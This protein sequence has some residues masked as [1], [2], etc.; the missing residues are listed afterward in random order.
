MRLFADRALL[1][2]GW[3][4]NVVLDM[5]AAGLITG[6]KPDITTP[7]ADAQR[8]GGPVLPGMPNLH[9]HAFQ[10]AFAGCSERRGPDEDSFWTWRKVMYDFAARITPDQVQSIAE[11]LYVEMLKAGYT[12]VAEFHYLHHDANGEPY[13]KLTEMSDRIF[14]AA[15]TTG[16]ALTH[17]P[18][19]YGYGGFGGQPATAGQRRFIND[20]ERYATLLE[21]LFA[22]YGK[23][24]NARIGIAAHSLRAVTPESLREAVQ[25][26]NRLDDSAPIHIHIAEQKKE[27]DDCL[28]WSGQRPVTWLFDNADIDERWCLVHAT[29]LD[30]KEIQALAAS[31]AVAGLCPTTEANLGDGLFPA[32]EYQRRGGTFGIGSDS[33]ISVSAVEELRTLEYG[34]RLL[35]RRRALLANLSHS[36]GASLYRDALRGGAQALGLAAGGLAVGRRAD[37]VVLDPE[38]PALINK[39]D[40]LLLDAVVFAGNVNPVKDVMVAGQWRIVDGHHL[41][42]EEIFGRFKQT[43]RQVGNGSIGS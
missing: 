43:Q 22:H 12:A 5:D 11:Q 26:I 34:Q 29:H 36:V 14:A 30:D 7:P 27:V 2:D 6:I 15:N 16:I 35:H 32:I 1:G 19:L 17:L 37:L 9:S 24:P 23:Q 40:D 38:T 28:A 41:L 21:T 20:I 39:P 18:V 3:G 4:R 33:H 42:E 13:A 10:R 31:R 25:L 8:L